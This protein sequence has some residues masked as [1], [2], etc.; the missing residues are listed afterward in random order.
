MLSAC[1]SKSP[2]SANRA[3][4]I[5][6]VIEQAAYDAYMKGDRKQSLSLLEEAYKR[7]AN[8]KNAL[9]YASALRHA[10]YHKRAAL[11]LR[12]FAEDQKN[13]NLD[14][15]LEYAST[16]AAM[17]DYV[18]TEQVA[19]NAVILAPESGRAY[20][21]LGIALDAQGHHDQA[22]VAFDKGLD[23]WQG[24]PSPILNNIGLNLAA[25]GFIDEAID[26]LRRALDTAP[27][28]REI[29]RNLRIVSALQYQPPAVGKAYVPSL[30]TTTITNINT[31]PKSRMYQRS[32]T[33]KL[34]RLRS[35]N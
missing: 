15:L 35:M 14:V 16:L 2:D 4:R 24:D 10:G 1:A 3:K 18:E 25:L 26:T 13:D 33:Q 20:H 23:R 21:V 27:D 12:P 6:S 19:R 30:I 7:K 32:I 34:N 28:R 17:G 8:E 29:E 22:R 31:P 5:D 9:A 11:I